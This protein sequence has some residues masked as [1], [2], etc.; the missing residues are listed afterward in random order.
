MFSLYTHRSNF[1][2]IKQFLIVNEP[3]R[4]PKKLWVDQG[5]EFFSKL[6]QECLDNNNILMHSTY[7]KGKSVIAERFMKTLKVKTIKK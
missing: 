6:M 2:K 7:N 3:N 1:Q 5:R 4:K